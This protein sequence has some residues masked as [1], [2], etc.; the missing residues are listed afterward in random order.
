MLRPLLLAMLMAALP[1]FAQ[2]DDDAPI[3]Y[4]DEEQEA[5]RDD[6]GMRELPGWS[7]PS[8]PDLREED[9]AEAEGEVD[10]ARL[11]DPNLGIGA[12][13]VGGALLLDSSRGQLVETRFAWGVR[14]N[15]EFGRLTTDDA[16]REALF[17]DVTWAY[18][19]MRDGTQ[20]IFV[21]SHYHFFTVAP[22]YELH[23]GGGKDY[24]FYGQ[25]GG[26]MAYQFSG[27]HHDGQE[28]TIAGVKPVF[29]Y[30]AGFR[31]RPRVG[32]GN[33]RIAFR[34]EVTRFRRGYMDDTLIAG[35]VGA[36]F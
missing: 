9:E 20:R 34:F 4:P 30:G 23:I 25:L 24:G 31:G 16:L 6:R 1:A 27:L 33:T 21:D 3:P 19:A 7:E 14:L 13:L 28:T 18:G 5:P 22:A 32:E 10:Y 26:G 11:D 8:A 36:S 12:E 29:Q 17:A 2:E 35:S 15:W